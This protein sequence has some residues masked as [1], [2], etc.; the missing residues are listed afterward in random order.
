VSTPD[1][2][3]YRDYT[4]WYVWA[5]RN[6]SMESTVCHGAAASA[7][8]VM[9]SGGTRVHAIEAARRSFSTGGHAVSGAADVRRRTYAE[10]FD[11]ARR[12][13]GGVR[14]QQ[15]AAAA[16]ALR[17]LDAG[18]GANV[19]MANARAA[20]GMGPPD[21]QPL[22][23]PPPPPA[24]P[25][26]PMAPA[27]WPGSAPPPPPPPPPPAQPP[28]G[29]P[30]YQA[31]APP[32]SYPPPGYA[33]AYAAPAYAPPGY[34]Y[35]PRAV[36]PALPYAGFGRRLVAF[37]L[38]LLIGVGAWVAVVAAITFVI[39]GVM[40]S[41]GGQTLNTFTQAIPGWV[42]L[43]Y[44][45]LGLVMTWLYYTLAE[46]SRWQGTVGKLALGIKVTDVNGARISWLRANARYWAKLLSF[47]IVGVGFLM[48]AFTE[49]GQGLHDM[50]AQTL[51]IT[52][53][54]PS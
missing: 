22:A 15:H 23:P 44:Y 42:T 49:R 2:E 21:P 54:P 13:L 45:P 53:R 7:T 12:E 41:V 3:A 38:D 30:A 47:L 40:L 17:T 20:A 46:A 43:S 18:H 31:T 35:A 39:A 24:A 8:E 32:P 48:I 29:P 33:P 16:A 10:W 28:V 9:Q 6:L 36:A 25:P 34:A 50:L 5:K 14:E 19:A 4:D 52:R 27:H 37:L 1:L 51:V 11:W 26:A